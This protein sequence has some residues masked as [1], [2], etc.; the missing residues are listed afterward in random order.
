MGS[1]C[2]QVISSRWM[3]YNSRAE[4]QCYMRDIGLNVDDVEL[5]Q[6]SRIIN[7]SV[8]SSTLMNKN[9]H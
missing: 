2:E 5:L 9:S 4:Y 6:P 3:A 1:C 8:R 7:Y